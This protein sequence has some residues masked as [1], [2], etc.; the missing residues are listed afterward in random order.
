MRITIFLALVWIAL[1]LAFLTGII[2]WL[3]EL[4]ALKA[5]WYIYPVFIVISFFRERRIANTPAPVRHPTTSTHNDDPDFDHSEES[6]TATEYADYE[7]HHQNSGGIIEAFGDL[8]GEVFETNRDNDD[9][10][11]DDY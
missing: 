11:D 4:Y 3:N 1:S 10:E 8:W 7:R 2:P 6:W 9:D 5:V